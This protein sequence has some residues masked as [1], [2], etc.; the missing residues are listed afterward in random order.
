MIPTARAF[1]SDVNMSTPVY[2]SLTNITSSA[3]IPPAVETVLLYSGTTGFPAEVSSVFNVT[4]VTTGG[5]EN[6]TVN[7]ATPAVSTV[8]PNPGDTPTV[9]TY[10]TYSLLILV[11][12][13]PVAIILTN[14]QL[15]VRRLKKESVEGV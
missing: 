15:K 11:F 2:N 12:M 1:T 14:W 5:T 7:S 9:I 3:L 10:Y 6:D 13:L 4:I 8:L